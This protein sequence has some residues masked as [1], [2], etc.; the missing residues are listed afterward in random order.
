MPLSTDID[1]RPKEEPMD[2]ADAQASLGSDGIIESH[3]TS[4]LMI[5][6]A[7]VTTTS[8]TTQSPIRQKNT[9]HIECFFLSSEDVRKYYLDLTCFKSI[10]CI[11][12]TSN[13]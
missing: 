8:T 6:C 7:S 2:T 5:E 13:E 3:P 12:S 1:D 4:A 10:V 9:V 11:E